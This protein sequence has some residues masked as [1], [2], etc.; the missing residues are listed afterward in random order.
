MNTVDYVLIALIAAAV[1][2]AVAAVIIRKR[3]GK[4]RCSDCASCPGCR[5]RAR[6]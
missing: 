1:A 3:K 4:G 6:R 2:A 5:D